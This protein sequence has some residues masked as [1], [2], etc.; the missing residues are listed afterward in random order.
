MKKDLQEFIDKKT[1]Y[2]EE[3]KFYES[4]TSKYLQDDCVLL[5]KKF[6][7]KAGDIYHLSFLLFMWDM[8]LSYDVFIL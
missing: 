2:D 1:S 4:F 5:K 3:L 7:V 8:R 6:V